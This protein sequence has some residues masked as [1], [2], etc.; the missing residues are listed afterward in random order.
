MPTQHI[1]IPPEE[2]GELRLIHRMQW[3]ALERC[4][5]RL[6]PSSSFWASWASFFLGL[7]VSGAVGFITVRFT[8]ATNS[9]PRSEAQ[10]LLALITIFAIVVAAIVFVMERRERKTR[11]DAIKAV[12][13][14]MSAIEGY[15]TIPKPQ[16][17]TII[18]AA[19]PLAPD[20]ESR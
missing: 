2:A 10:T 11:T 12:T 6:S 8:I 5:K 7:A 1:A 18:S 14:E 19:D 16:V 20:P 17:G 9:D 4:V 13:D 3:E 15:M